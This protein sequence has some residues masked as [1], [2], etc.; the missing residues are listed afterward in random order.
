MPHFGTPFRGLRASFLYNRGSV[1][2]I[3]FGLIA[4]LTVWSCGSSSSSASLNSKEAVRKAVLAHLSSRQGLDLNM[5]AMDL[6][7]GDVSFRTDEADATVSFRAKGSQTAAMTIKYGL[8]REG[9]GWKVK[10]KAATEGG[11]NPHGA[12]ALPLPPPTGSSGGAGLPSGHPP[13][14]EKK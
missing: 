13:V 2:N 12:G 1:R 6:D 9:S 7:V 11:A 5:E 14:P 4:A 8:V 10:P 3:I